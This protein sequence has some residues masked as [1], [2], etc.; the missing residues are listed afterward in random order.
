MNSL[1]WEKKIE[2]EKKKVIEILFSWV[3]VLV[4]A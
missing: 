3:Q 1:V 2:R 4:V